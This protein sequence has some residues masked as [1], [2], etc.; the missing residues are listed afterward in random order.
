MG[1]R[2]PAS[3]RRSQPNANHVRT[4]KRKVLANTGC[5]ARSPSNMISDNHRADSKS[6]ARDPDKGSRAEMISETAESVGVAEPDVAPR[7]T[8]ADGEPGND[9]DQEGDQN[10]EEDRGC[11]LRN[12]DEFDQ[13]CDEDQHRQTVIDQRGR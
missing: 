7:D 4:K 3:A 12:D 9:V 8:N 11:R 10:Q 6:Q 1:R 13:R 5:L 2:V